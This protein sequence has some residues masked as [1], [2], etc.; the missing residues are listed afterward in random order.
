[1]KDHIYRPVRHALAAGM[2]AGLVLGLAGP[3]EIRAQAPAGSARDLQAQ[4][5]VLAALGGEPRIVSGAGMT[6]DDVPLLTLENGSPFD[7][8][9]PERRLVVV[10]GLDGSADA[11]RIVLDAVRWFK[12]EAPEARSAH[13]G[14]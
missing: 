9:R 5:D 12:T 13:D 6:R 10:G 3:P 2:A 11:A 1:M 8:T 14:W 4:L 7:A